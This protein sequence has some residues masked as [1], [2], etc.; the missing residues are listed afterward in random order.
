[1]GMKCASFATWAILCL[2]LPIPPGAASELGLPAGV[3]DTQNPAD[4]SLSPL[5]SL[6]RIKVPDGF[7]VTLFAAEPHVRRPIAFDFDDRGRL[8]VV[9]NYSHPDWQA[10]NTSD[11]VIILE[12]TDLDG[13]FDSRKVF[14]DKGRYLSGIAVG[15]GGVWLANTPELTFIPDRNRDDVPDGQPE[16]ILDGFRVSNNNVVN[17]LHWGPDG[18]LYGAIGLPSPSFVGKPGTPK[19]ERVHMTRGMWRFHP[20]R[21]EFEQIATGMVNPWGADFNEFGDL[22]TTNTVIAH[23]WHIVPGMHC[24]RRAF[25]RDNPFAYE[26]IQSI[27]NHLHWGGGT[28]QNSRNSDDEHH[29]IAGGGHA[30]CGC[31]IYLGDNWP[32][33]YRGTLFTGNLHGNRLNNDRLEPRA[34][35]YVGVHANDFLFAN[36]P[37]FRSMSQKY[38]PDGGVFVSDWHDFGECHDK[39]G[40]HRSSGRIYKITFSKPKPPL[41]DLAKMTPGELV[42]LHEHRNEWYVRHARRLLHEYARTARD[43]AQLKATADLMKQRFEAS[44]E[45][46]QRLRYLWTIYLTNGWSIEDLTKLAAHGDPHVRR[47]AI[48]LL[49]DAPETPPTSLDAMLKNAAGDKD[50]TVRLAAASGLHR[51]HPKDRLPIAAVLSGHAQDASDHYLPLMTWYAMEPAVPLDPDASLKLA[52]ESSIPLIRRFVVRRL[53][54]QRRYPLDSLIGSMADMPDAALVDMMRGLAE[55][56][57]STRRTAPPS[58]KR[59]RER[60]V[61]MNDD[62]VSSLVTRAAIAM[63][64]KQA[65]AAMRDRVLDDAID[66]D[67]R[68]SN[69][70]A[71]LNIQ[72]AVNASFLHRIV[73]EQPELRAIA[74]KG[75]ASRSTTATANVLIDL[76]PELEERTLSEVMGILALRLDTAKPLLAYLAENPRRSSSLSVYSLQ[77]L[78][79][80]EDPTMQ[81]SI[82]RL[83]PKSSATVAKAEQLARYRRLLTPQYL[84]SGSASAGRRLFDATCAKC[85]R[86]FGEG[87][88]LAPDLTGSGRAN[89]DY[90]LQNLVDPSGLVDAAYRMTTVITDDGRLLTGLVAKHDDHSVHLKTEHGLV[91]LPLKEVES[92]TTSS[93][94]MMPDGLLDVYT[95]EQVRDLVVYLASPHQVEPVGD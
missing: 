73:R 85:H 70:K 2:L 59:L 7:N 32:E 15:H 31:M 72:D 9:E 41:S 44:A 66:V 90:V 64:D 69:L 19:D 75:L 74:I 37:W 54:D 58:W 29:H 88:D 55:G 83:W 81:E 91:K 25:E 92:F 36:D 49:L 62:E 87:G 53:V 13:Q 79:E 45:T 39:D 16:P 43:I 46:T 5:E 8:W 11:R 47:W 89:L 17:N 71:L 34:S 68:I 78:R 77:R 80:F 57:E 40:S 30:H 4:V 27:T 84:D 28:W 65:V 82:D 94:S 42:E 52:V 1:M 61:R 18:W 76:F 86:L 95:P 23:L 33:Q 63:G 51:I 93:K 56:L 67:S 3:A 22:I 10:E 21:H 60:A 35:S 48:K 38:G 24:E 50:A 20:Y 6:A 26:R 14:W 12:D